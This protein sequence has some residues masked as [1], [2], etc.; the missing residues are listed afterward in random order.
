LAYSNDSMNAPA[1]QLLEFE[2]A[3]AVVQ[4]HASAMAPPPV[5]SVPLAEARGRV[6]AA[7]IAADR[8]QPP[9]HRSTR[10]GFAVRAAELQAGALAV[11][12]TIHA[13]EQW[14]GGALQSGS[15]IEIM[16]GAPV[17]AGA[18]AVVMVEHTCTVGARIAL[19]EGRA[20]AAGENIVPAGSEARAGEMLLAPGRRLGAAEIALAASCGAASVSVYRRPRVAILATGDEL[21]EPAATPL[22][23]QIRNSNSYALAA[24][25][26]DAGGEAVRLPTAADTRTALDAAVHGALDCDLLLLSGGV[27]A[28]KRD[29]VEPALAA[30]GAEFL[31][32]GVLMQPG[33]PVVFG[34]VPPRGQR[35]EQFFFGLPGNPVSTQVTFLAFAQCMIAALSGAAD[36][37]PRFVQ[38]QLAEE[39]QVKPG[40]TRFLPAI[41]THDLRRPQVQIIA[42]QG[43]GDLAANARANCYAVFPEGSSTVGAGRSITVLL[44]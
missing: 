8:D 7:A 37:A 3:L 24:L 31:F 17:P 14:V 6:L 11:A 13:G 32:T 44:R 2:E 26:E 30:L 25:V 20:I 12:G 23:H 15:A 28:G 40:L 38:A 19:A 9:F 18:D 29:L 34:R 1:Q 39:V 36:G 33:K 16:T 43:S 4:R 42:S 27:S 10:D 41:L 35:R 5:E 22:P 21:V